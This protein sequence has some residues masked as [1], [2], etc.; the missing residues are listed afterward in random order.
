MKIRPRII[1]VLAIQGQ[2]LVKTIKFDKPKYIGDPINAIK[3]FNEKETD[4]L[5]ILDIRASVKSMEPNYKLIEE[6]AGEAFMPVGYGGG[7]STYEQAKKVFDCGVEKVILNS[8]CMENPKVISDV[9]AQYGNQSVVACVDYKKTFLGKIKPVFYSGTKSVSE[10]LLTWVKRL[11]DLG[12]GEII[13]QNVERDGTFE[14]F[15][16]PT[17]KK[18]ASEINVPLVPCGGAHSVSEMIGTIAETGASAAAAGSI[19]VFKNNNRESILINYNN[20]L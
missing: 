20:K 7:I 4:E 1:P 2:Q 15:D 3:I 12:A 9:A 11:Q 10:D 19:F 16:M 17:I 6:M 5:V 14:G 8:V 13:L 18:I